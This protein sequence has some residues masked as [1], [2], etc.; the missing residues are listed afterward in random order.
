MNLFILFFLFF[1]FHLPGTTFL[2]D[3]LL[4]GLVLQLRLNPVLHGED[5][6]DGRMRLRNVFN[7][8]HLSH[9]CESRADGRDRNKRHVTLT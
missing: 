2:D 6:Q 1:F 7:V 4:L 5:A 8:L 3:V 9:N